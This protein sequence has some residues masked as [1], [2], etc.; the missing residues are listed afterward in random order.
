MEMVW[1]KCRGKSRKT[2]RGIVSDDMELID[3]NEQFSGMCAGT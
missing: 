3:L 2:W 1:E